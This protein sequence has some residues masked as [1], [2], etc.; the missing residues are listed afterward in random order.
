MDELADGIMIA[1]EAVRAGA[2]G[3]PVL[4]G[5]VCAG[6]GTRVFPPVPVCP[7]CMSDDMAPRELPRQGK[8][9]SWSVV[10]VAPKRWTVPYIAGYVDLDEGV[11]VFAHIVDAEPAALEMDME[12]A[13]R[14]AT[15]GAEQDGTARRS[16]AFAP[17]G[18]DG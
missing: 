9:Y 3:A 6:C 5:S 12:V 1:G 2:D 17:V 10:H 11:R 8:L 13:L 16:Y 7:E 18:K 15:L 4:V 14:V